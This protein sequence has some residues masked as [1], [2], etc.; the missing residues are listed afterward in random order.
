MSFMVHDGVGRRS[1]SSKGTDS[2]HE[3][4]AR[5][6][7]QKRTAGRTGTSRLSTLS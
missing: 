6:H 7:G 3:Q 5:K 4:P 1:E 2:G